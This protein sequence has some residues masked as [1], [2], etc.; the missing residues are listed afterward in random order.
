MKL[1]AR[2][3]V[4]YFRSSSVPFVHKLLALFAIA[5]VASPVDLVPDT[6]PVLGWLDDVGVVALIAAFYVRQINGWLATE[7]EKLRSTE[8]PKSPAQDS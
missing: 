8:E 1:R 3:A 4:A 2:D 6:I 7:E 5:Y